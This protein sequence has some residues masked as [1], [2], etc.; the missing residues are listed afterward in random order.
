MS[1]RFAKLELLGSPQELCE[2]AQALAR[3]KPPRLDRA[4][5]LCA[6]A[7]LHVHEPDR[8]YTRVTRLVGA[9]LRA[10]GMYREALTIAWYEQD[11][12]QQ[13]FLAPRVPAIDRARTLA[14]RAEAHPGRRAEL[15]REAAV[16][17]E[18]DGLFVRAAL[19]FEE[20]GDPRASADLLGKLAR[21]LDDRLD[22]TYPA[23][24][25]WFG[26]AR[27]T[28]AI[29]EKQRT[30]AAVISAVHR[31]ESAADAFEQG[32]QRERAFDCW[33]I[34]MEVGKLASTFEHVMEGAVNA[35]RILREDNLR[36]HALRL[37]EHAI[38]LAREAG[39]HSGAAILAREMTLYARRHG[40]TG[41]ATRAMLEQ[42]RLWQ[43]AAEANREREGPTDLSDN[44]LLAALLCY[45]ELGQYQRVF[46]LYGTL[47]QSAGNLSRR[48]HFAR[49]ARRYRDTENARLD[50][51]A[52]SKEGIELVVPADIWRAD[53]LEWEAA[54]SAVEACTDALLSRDSSVDP[55]G[56]RLALVGRLA[57]LAAESPTRD[58]TE[59]LA[60]CEQLGRIKLY[61][62]LAP[63]EKLC[64]HEDAA[65]RRAAIEALARYFYKRTFQSLERALGDTDPG[66]VEAATRAIERLRF[67]HASQPLA[68]I[69]KSARQKRSRLA[70]LRALA[71]LDA[72][73]ATELLLSVLES[74]DGDERRAALD[75]LKLS[76]P[77][78]FVAAARSAYPL[79]SP[80]L[81]EAL[82]TVLNEGPG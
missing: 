8:S 13:D 65:V 46:D 71:H 79:A 80:A 27:A 76:R 3:E 61:G 39:E 23:A 30:E 47:A 77:P 15:C 50:V 9:L 16:L 49:A 81:K 59:L 33:S 34:M 67:P 17:L 55:V 72:E 53:L 36:H 54:G 31:L 18:R 4:L 64:R 62:L 63:L 25:A 14:L 56:K 19:Y 78:Q 12:E 60:L 22:A 21:L 37:Y 7:L 74:G 5:E 1:L 70:A 28:K 43:L 10:K 6:A 45:A 69:Y 75:E 35:I 57:A 24:L 44:A 82:R 48:S 52:A 73:D 40:A 2:A 11:V 20:A 66:V 29:D 38:D 26:V 58:G 68:R 32:C 42:A 41:V 51:A